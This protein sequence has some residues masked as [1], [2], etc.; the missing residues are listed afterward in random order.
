MTFV[1][2]AV[3]ELNDLRQFEKTGIASGYARKMRARNSATDILEEK[4]TLPA[5][6]WHASSVRTQDFANRF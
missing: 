1:S 2:F 4:K 6:S 5:Q 3:S